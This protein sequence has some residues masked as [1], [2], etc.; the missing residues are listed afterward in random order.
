MFVQFFP[1]VRFYIKRILMP[2]LS[3]PAANANQPYEEFVRL[4]V[5]HEPGLRG[6]LRALL[7]AWDDVDEVMQQTSLVAWRKFSQFEPGTNFMAWAAAIGRFEALKHLRA[8]SRDRLVFS[9][10]VLDLIAD[11]VAAEPEKLARERAALENCLGKLDATSRELL[12]LSYQPGAKFHEVAA[13]AGKSVQGY[14]K[15]VQR[16]RARLLACIEGELKKETA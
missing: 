4:L 13:R 8:R 12:R 11:E 15:T 9:P 6:F 2:D 7:P 10:E 3:D 5:A 14:Y 16:L 1:L